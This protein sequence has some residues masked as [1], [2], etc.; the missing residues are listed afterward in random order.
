MNK[1]DLVADAISDAV[2][3]CQIEETRIALDHATSPES[4]A[5]LWAQLRSLILARSPAQVERMER[6]MGLR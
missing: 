2:R 1:L 5:A 6:Q 3:E 4:R